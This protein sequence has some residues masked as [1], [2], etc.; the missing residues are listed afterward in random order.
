MACARYLESLV[1]A[2]AD[3][4]LLCP[5]NLSIVCFRYRPPDFNGDLNALN[6]RIL[7]NVQR[8][9]S[10]YVSNARIG[11]AFALRA[12]VLNYRTSMRDME[13]LLRDTRDAARE[14]S[15]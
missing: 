15:A 6:E 4:E 5:A 2:A 12:C 9:G 10:S 8:A 1:A 13:I 3:F 11:E 14:V 7:A